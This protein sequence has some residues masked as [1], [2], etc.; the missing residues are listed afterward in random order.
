MPFDE[1]D[2][3]A[4]DAPGAPHRDADPPRAAADA[5]PS[6]LRRLTHTPLRDLLRLRATG[7]LDTDSALDASGLPESTRTLIKRVVKK[8]RLWPLERADVAHELIAHFRDAAPPESLETLASPK[9]PESSESPESHV[10]AAERA[11]GDPRAAARLIARAKRRNRPLPVRFALRAIKWGGAAALLLACV[12]AYFVVRFYGDQPTITRD[13][14]SELY[15][16]TDRPEHE[17]AAPLYQLAA[18]TLRTEQTLRPERVIQD[19]AWLAE[20]SAF[21]DEHCDVLNAVYEASSR[22]VLGYTPKRRAADGTPIPLI[23]V[24]HTHLNDIRH[25]GRAL[26]TDAHVAAAESDGPRL[27]RAL[28]AMPALARH[29][30]ESP[31]LIADLVSLAI[32]T[33][34]A[35]EAA[36]FLARTPSLF[37]DDD[38]LALGALARDNRDIANVRLEFERLQIHDYA[39]RVYTD[40]G[41]G[42]GRATGV[43]LATLPT[44]V[45]STLDDEYLSR[46]TVIAA[47]VAPAVAAFLPSR[48][49]LLEKADAFFDAIVEEERRPLWERDYARYLDLES[50]LDSNTI[51]AKRY[52]LLDI[53]LPSLWQASTHGP[54]L[55]QRLDALEVSLAIERFRRDHNR[56]PESLDEL[57]PAYISAAPL[58]QFD[59]EPLRYRV[60]DGEPVLYSVGF[61]RVDDGGAPFTLKGKTIPGAAGSRWEPPERVRELLANPHAPGASRYGLNADWV[62]FS[63]ALARLMHE[64]RMNPP[65]PEREFEA[66][67]EWDE[68][69]A[70]EPDAQID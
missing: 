1:H 62:L 69:G 59:G 23:D 55:R 58:D 20:A 37:T 45:G 33:M 36:D 8:T 40:D 10:I 38:L 17:R 44:Y 12:Y 9:S 4:N 57:A 28:R 64:Q 42:D 6:Y 27:V 56:W 31:A 65:D 49:A 26:R 66:M 39:Q 70:N 14:F 2:H 29:A 43:G 24:Y 34:W 35:N 63:P 54:L 13:Y 22:P 32:L 19:A 18:N 60:V 51:G 47:L 11:F 48:R 41:K 7:R 50:M 46:P 15:P 25:C 61:D 21:F 53:L 52:F 5:A 67:Y 68:S 3:I 16:E 30:R